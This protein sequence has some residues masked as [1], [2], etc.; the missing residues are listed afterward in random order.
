MEPLFTGDRGAQR[1]VGRLHRHLK[2]SAAG[3]DSA[4]FDLLIGASWRERVEARCLKTRA[5]MVTN[6][7]KGKTKGLLGCKVKIIKNALAPR[8]AH[9]SLTNV[10]D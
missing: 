2:A 10:I 5:A 6:A 7:A 3:D 4:S 1:A 9:Y 8:S